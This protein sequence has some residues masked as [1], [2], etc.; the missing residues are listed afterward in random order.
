MRSGKFSIES[1]QDLVFSGFTEGENWN[2]WAC[3]YFT[4]EESQKIVKAHIETGQK[5]SYNAI[6]DAFHFEVSNEYDFYEAIEISGQKLYPI[7]NSNWIWEEI[8]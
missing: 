5:A 6:L 1:K 7:G 3:P 2:G 8:V 4:F